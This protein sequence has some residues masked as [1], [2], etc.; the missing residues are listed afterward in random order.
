M[1]AA[2]K[3]Q[4]WMAT[5]TAPCIA[6]GAMQI[7][8]GIAIAG[9]ARIYPSF[10]LPFEGHVLLGYV[11]IYCGV[12][13][14]VSTA[15]PK[16]VSSGSGNLL[17]VLFVGELALLVT[18]LLQLGL[19]AE[20]LFSTPVQLA[21][22]PL[23][24]SGTLALALY[25]ALD[26]YDREDRKAEEQQSGE[27]E[28]GEIEETADELAEPEEQT[29][30]I[31]RGIE[32]IAF[33][34]WFAVLYV[35][36]MLV[37]FVSMFWMYG[38]IR[39]ESF[40][41]YRFGSE[42]E[43]LSLLDAFSLENPATR[44]LVGLLAVWAILYFLFSVFQWIS[45]LIWPYSNRE[46]SDAEIDFILDSEQQIRDYIIEN[47]F[48]RRLWL[49][50]AYVLFF[51][52]MFVAAAGA[53]SWLTDQLPLL[54]VPKRFADETV[55][56]VIETQYW[57]LIAGLFSL[58]LLSS[59]FYASFAWMFPKLAE[60][61]TG[62][63][64]IRKESWFDL[65]SWL[66]IL[67]R[68]GM[69]RTDKPLDPGW[70]LRYSATCWIPLFVWPG[71]VLLAVSFGMLQLDRG[72]FDLVTNKRVVTVDYWTQT[73]HSY[74]LASVSTVV[75][76][77]TFDKKTPKPAY[78]LRLVDGTDV[79]LGK[80][81]RFFNRLPEIEA[82]D[83]ELRALGT[84]AEFLVKHPWF[85]EPV[86]AYSEPCIEASTSDMEPMEAVRFRVLMRLDQYKYRN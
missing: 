17:A 24:V 13:L 85:E 82:I 19:V 48:K 67:V 66:T 32:W 61:S 56:L 28:D 35:V 21:Y 26:V 43:L 2:T 76:E 5:L 81:N 37:W 74:P 6:V 12:V 50:G 62:A 15:F 79:R 64:L 49:S 22:A 46:L 83:S 38:R 10:E 4:R 68:Y 77:C 54:G 47:N 69:I 72:N 86:I 53:S 39:A 60:S 45:R 8:A 31:R 51:I 3:F 36:P 52:G 59:L 23:L 57:S 33:H 55:F 25:H 80:G 75:L 18:G 71:L 41:G 70:F 11:L 42:T 9:L 40:E 73:Q 16:A 1:P 27:E 20:A 44:T 34:A 30:A 14:T 29:S 78:T 58:V 65:V 7:V 84:R 63:E